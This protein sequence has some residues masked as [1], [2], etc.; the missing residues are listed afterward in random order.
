[1]SVSRFRV[2][3]RFDGALSATVE[4]DRGASLI[5]VRPRHR[6]RTFELPLAAVAE[7]VIW[8]VVAAELREK[9]KAKAAKRAARRSA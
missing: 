9:K 2:H 3:G 4:I 6:H 7:M 8:R 1:M 5:S